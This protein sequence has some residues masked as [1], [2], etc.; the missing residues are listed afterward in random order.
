MDFVT[1]MGHGFQ[2][3]L[4]SADSGLAAAASISSSPLLGS[5]PPSTWGI[6]PGQIIDSSESLS[7]WKHIIMWDCTTGEGDAVVDFSSRFFFCKFRRRSRSFFLFVTSVRLDLDRKRENPLTLHQFL[8]Q[9]YRLEPHQAL[10]VKI[11]ELTGVGRENGA[12][13]IVK[14]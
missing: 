3:G 6:N 2:S 14:A 10:P 12:A 4:A 1:V 13:T 9:D 8:H 5:P 11:E 7:G